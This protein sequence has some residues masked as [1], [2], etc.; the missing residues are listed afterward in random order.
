MGVAGPPLYIYIKGKWGYFGLFIHS[1]SV[2][3]DING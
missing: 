1:F 2:R 3:E